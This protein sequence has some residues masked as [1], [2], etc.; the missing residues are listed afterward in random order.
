MGR[1]PKSAL[2]SAEEEV[3]ETADAVEANSETDSTPEEVMVKTPNVAMPIESVGNAD[4]SGFVAL[5]DKEYRALNDQQR[6]YYHARRSKHELLT[7][8]KTMFMV[9]LQPGEK[10][11]AT[12]TVSIN[13]YRLNV[14]KG[15]M[16][17]I[18]VPMAQAIAE[19]YQIEMEAG[20]N[21]LFDRDDEHAEA[22]S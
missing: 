20:S 21:M 8:P 9:P 22:L 3:L 14:K 5:S 2:V 1:K 18:P 10:P 7:G 15:A 4:I 17:K 11:G 16:V 12:E 19:K 13:G 6:E